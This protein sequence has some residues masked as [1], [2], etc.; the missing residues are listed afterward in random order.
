MAVHEEDNRFPEKLH[1]SILFL[2]LMA[3]MMDEFCPLRM[4]NITW[5]RDI[6]PFSANIR[7]TFRC[8]YSCGLYE[9]LIKK[10]EDKDLSLK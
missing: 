3:D 2:R 10:R 5:G 7:D 9:S 6:F 1:W 4:G 8:C